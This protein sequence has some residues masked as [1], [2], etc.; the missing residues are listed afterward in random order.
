MCIPCNMVYTS[1]FLKVFF[2]F[3]F[4]PSITQPQAS[5][6]HKVVTQYLCSLALILPSLSCVFQNSAYIYGNKI[7]AH[8]LAVITNDWL[9]QVKIAILLTVLRAHY[10][11][12][13]GSVLVAYVLPS[14]LFFF[15]ILPCFSISI[16]I[17]R[18]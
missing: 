15:V 8:D 6:F 10:S 9:P 12:I 1:L 5:N 3:C 18:L 16:T 17:L 14:S 2:L 13:S 11:L 7:S 4:L